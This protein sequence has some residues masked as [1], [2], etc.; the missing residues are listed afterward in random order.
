ME[1]AAR[2]HPEWKFVL[3]GRVEHKRILAL[4]KLP[5]VEFTG[6]VPHSELHEYMAR[7]RVATSCSGGPIIG[8]R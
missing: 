4:K 3:I 5:N 2:A 6:E 1:R 7:F 8:M